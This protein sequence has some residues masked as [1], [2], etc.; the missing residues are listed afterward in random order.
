MLKYLVWPLWNPVGHLNCGWQIFRPMHLPL[1]SSQPC[2]AWTVDTLMI[3]A[4]S[5]LV[6]VEWSLL[7]YITVKTFGLLQPYFGRLSCMHA[8]CVH[9]THYKFP[10]YHSHSESECSWEASPFCY[11]S[12]SLSEVFL[13]RLAFFRSYTSDPGCMVVVECQECGMVVVGLQSWPQYCAHDVENFRQ[14]S[15]FLLMVVVECQE[16]NQ[17]AIGF[18]WESPGESPGESPC[19]ETVVIA[20]LI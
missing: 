14:S 16:C 13:V 19:G 9:V 17:I 4:S 7:A 15:T 12:V 8:C 3:T 2:S 1:I 6:K 10:G 5:C 18:L 11:L 20:V